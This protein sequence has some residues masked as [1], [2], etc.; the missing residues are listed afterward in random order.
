MRDI[1]RRIMMINWMTSINS[2]KK[3]ED[4]NEDEEDDVFYDAVEGPPVIDPWNLPTNIK[5]PPLPSSCDTESMSEDGSTWESY[6][7]TPFYCLPS[8]AQISPLSKSPWSSYAEQSRPASK[9]NIGLMTS[10][11]R[12]EGHIYSL[13]AS[14]DF[15]YT[16]SSSKNIRIWKHNMEYSGFKT[17][18]GLV[19]AIVISGE[20]IFTGHQDGKIRVWRATRKDP[21]VHKK[22]G[23]LP[24][25]QAVFKKSLKRKNYMEV[26]KNHSEIWIKHFDAISSLCLNEDHTLLYSVSWDKTMKVWRVMDFKCLESISAHDDLINTVVTG[27]HGLVFSGSADGTLKVWRKESQGKRPKHYLLHT[28]LK[29]EFAVTSLAVNPAGMVVYA[30]CSDGTVHFWE[31]EKLIHGGVLRGH[32][33]AVLCL[34]A[35]RNLVF[36]GS[37]DKNICV[38]QRDERGAH[39][40]LYL[41]NGHKG[42]VKCLAVEEERREAKSHGDSGCIT[43]I[44]Y[45]GSLD[46]SVKIWRMCPHVSQLDNHHLPPPSPQRINGLQQSRPERQNNLPHPRRKK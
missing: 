9:D 23:T 5:L 2:P 17:H 31:H 27:F 11:V 39:R 40:C 15:L 44:L 10:L 36:S 13:A 20:K 41:L 32:K 45:S 4:D 19:K 34:A 46:K 1:L 26:G 33:L 16:G 8:S 7:P 21:K 28:L 12:E 18:S 25:F 24:N 6:G 38:W 30:G 29:Q 14:G 3:K 43:C 37:A 22:V 42:P 35:L